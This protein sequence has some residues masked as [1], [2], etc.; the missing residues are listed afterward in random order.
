M[1]KLFWAGLVLLIVVGAAAAVQVRTRMSAARLGSDVTYMLDGQGDAVVQVVEKTYFVDTETERNFDGL[2]ARVGH[3]DA[4]AFRRGVE[5]SLK[6]LAERIGRQMVVSDFEASFDRQPEYGAVVYRFRWA[7]FAEWRDGA[8]A[9][10][11]KAAD[12]IRLNKDSSLSI[13]LPRGAALVKA[14]P[15]PVRVENGGALLVWT[16][17]GEMA[18]PYIEYR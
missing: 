10:D 3:P 5:S 4:E 11:F 14:E 6:R 16:G 18:W 1:R 8:W 13:A 9:V 12:P 17:A 2:M 15:A 7:G